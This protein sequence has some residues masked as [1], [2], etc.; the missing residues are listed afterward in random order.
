MR[1]TTDE[2]K[3]GAYPGISDGKY[4]CISWAWALCAVPTTT[5]KA[6]AAMIPRCAV[7]G[8]Q[9]LPRALRG[10]HAEAKQA[11][12]ECQTAAP[13]SKWSRASAGRGYMPGRRKP[14]RQQRLKP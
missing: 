9:V 13:R 10:N 11:A 8:R 14:A 6:R 4:C 5:Q 12:A 1:T 3:S 2:L 7:L